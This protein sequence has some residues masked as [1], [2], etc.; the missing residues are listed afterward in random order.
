MKISLRF[1]F[2]L[3]TRFLPGMITMDLIVLFVILNVNIVIAFVSL[4]I[5]S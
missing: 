2:V 3:R 4:D 5:F 1:L